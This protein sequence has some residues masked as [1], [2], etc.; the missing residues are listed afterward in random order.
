[1]FAARLYI[2]GLA[3]FH[4]KVV[5]NLSIMIMATGSISLH[6]NLNLDVLQDEPRNTDTHCISV[7]CLS[8]PLSWKSF[9]N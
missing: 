5:S 9:S 6:S 8:K 3:C 4:V 2:I 1:M 7:A